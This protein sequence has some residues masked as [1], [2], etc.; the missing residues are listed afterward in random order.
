M[1]ITPKI[2]NSTGT[3]TSV[4]LNNKLTLIFIFLTQGKTQQP[5][6]LTCKLNLRP[7]TAGYTA[8]TKSAVALYLA[9][10]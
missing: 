2:V 9:L 7:V 5:A 1:T 3:G 10:Q 6:R 4:R 8:L